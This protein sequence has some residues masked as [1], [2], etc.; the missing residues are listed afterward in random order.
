MEL[1]FELL[2]RADTWLRHKFA[3]T[4]NALGKL[5][6]T[7]AMEC[8]VYRAIAG[9]AR[10]TT[11]MHTTIAANYHLAVYARAALIPKI[12]YRGNIHV[13][14]LYARKLPLNITAA[15]SSAVICNDTN[16]ATYLASLSRL[17][18]VLTILTCCITCRN[19]DV[20]NHILMRE[21]ITSVGVESLRG[22]LRREVE[23]NND[24]LNINDLGVLSLFTKRVD[25]MAQISIY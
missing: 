4:S 3:C 10:P 23:E 13:R 14:D 6:T 20:F 15:M 16:L 25:T 12:W 22:Y 18:N 5:A 19:Y 1:V 9:G 2:C 8:P 7:I 21:K 24:D 11:Q 17:Y